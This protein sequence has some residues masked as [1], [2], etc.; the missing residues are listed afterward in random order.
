MQLS[1]ECLPS[2]DSQLLVRFGLVLL[3]RLRAAPATSALG[4]TLL[5][6]RLAC[7]LT[8]T[9][10]CY[11]Q[12]SNEKNEYDLVKLK[13]VQLKKNSH[14]MALMNERSELIESVVAVSITR[15]KMK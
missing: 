6:S 12:S 14:E 3:Y 13:Q 15:Q 7:L 9:I 10:T 11:G 5:H 8:S 4:S 2:I 1:E